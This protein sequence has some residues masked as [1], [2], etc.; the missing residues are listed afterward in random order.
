[1]PGS[2]RSR[3][4]YYLA[5]IYLLVTVSLIMLMGVIFALRY[6]TDNAHGYPMEETANVGVVA[7]TLPWSIG[8]TIAAVALPM[9]TGRAVFV[10]LSVLAA[11]INATILYFFGYL[12]SKAFD[13]FRR[14][15]G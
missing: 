6:S 14:Q 5:G 10:V 12:L 11:L 3:P 1:M 7:L 8:S 9:Y 4:G 2:R 15:S 13:Y